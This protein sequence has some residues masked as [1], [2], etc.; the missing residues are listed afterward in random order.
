MYSPNNPGSVTTSHFRLFRRT[1]KLADMVIAGNA[2]L[3]E[4]AKRFN[5]NVNILPTGLNTNEYSEKNTMKI[6]SKIRLVWIG[7]SS[8][9]KYLNEIMPA[10]EEI[11]SRFDNVVLRI[12]CDRFFDLKNMDVEKCQWSLENQAK[13]LLT[14]DIGLAP[15]PDN[16]FILG[17]CGFKILQYQAAHLPTVAS[18]AGVNSDFVRDGTTGFFVDDIAQ[19]TER[20]ACLIEN[21]DL[22]KQMADAANEHVKKFDSKII[23]ERFSELI[24]NFLKKTSNNI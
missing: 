15:L 5:N 2:Y 7:S 14:A 4:Q 16:R 10:F 22:R 3:A 17:K 20:I 8:T 12:I 9:L 6:D 11:G 23:G 13:D 18:P 24:T 21:P 1:A 19:W